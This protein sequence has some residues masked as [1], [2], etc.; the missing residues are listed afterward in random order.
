LNWAKFYELDAKK[1]REILKGFDE[2]ENGTRRM[3][4]EIIW[5]LFIHRGV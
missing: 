1:T 4:E 3:C 5:N 2:Y